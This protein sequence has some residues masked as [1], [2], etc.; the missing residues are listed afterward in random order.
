[1]RILSFGGG[2]VFGLIVGAVAGVIAGV[3]GGSQDTELDFCGDTT[4]GRY[5]QDTQ[6]RIAACGYDS[7]F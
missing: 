4:S 5:I 6:A 2:L 7:S 3:F 1:M